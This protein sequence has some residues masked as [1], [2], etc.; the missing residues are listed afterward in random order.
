MS[1]MR[2]L[3]AF[4]YLLL[5]AVVFF[6]FVVAFN[7]ALAN[8]AEAHE[9]YDFSCCNKTDC[10]PTTIGEVKRQVDGWLIVPT[11]ELI[12]FSGDPRLKQSMDPLMHRC[13]YMKATQLKRAGD[14][15][16]L[17]VATPGG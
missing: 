6:V 2:P 10:R 16:C 13:L 12:P 9:W 3:K 15:R 5:C 14:T 8:N 4:G 11:G 1:A 7:A 17:Y